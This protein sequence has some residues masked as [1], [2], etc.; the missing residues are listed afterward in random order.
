MTES[1]AIIGA[2]RA[3]PEPGHRRTLRGRIMRVLAPATLV[4]FAVA[5]IAAALYFIQ[6]GRSRLQEQ[7]ARAITRLGSAA[8]EFMSETVALAQDVAS[9]AA[10]QNYTQALVAGDSESAVSITR[11]AAVESLA[12]LLERY[13][14]DVLIASFVTHSGS[15]WGRAEIDPSGQIITMDDAVVDTLATD[16]V[17]QVAFNAPAG[18]AVPRGIELRRDPTNPDSPLAP[19]IRVFMPVTLQGSMDVGGLIALDVRADDLLDA[20]TRAQDA[21]QPLIGDTRTLVLDTGG[22]VLFDSANPNIVDLVTPNSLASQTFPTINQALGAQETLALAS[23]GE[24]VISSATVSF[25]GRPEDYLRIV[26]INDINQLQEAGLAQAAF[27]IGGALVSGLVLIGISY[28]LLGRFTRPVQRFTAGLAAGAAPEP[29]EPL[30]EDGDEISTLINAY[31]G[32]QAHNERLSQQLDRQSRRFNRTFDVAARVSS[33]AVALTGLDEMLNRTIDQICREYDFYHA[34]VFLLDDVAKDAVLVYSYGEAGRQLLDRKHRLAVG[35]N[36]LVGQA[37]AHSRPMIVNDTAEPGDMPWRFNPLL[38]DTSAEMALPLRIGGQVLGVLDLQSVHSNAFAEEDMRSFLLLADQIAIA[39]NNARLL[40]QSQERI[41]QIDILNRQLTRGAWEEASEQ[42]AGKTYVYDLMQVRPVHGPASLPADG[43]GKDIPIAIRGEVVGS[44]QAGGEDFSTEDEA[45]LRAVADRVGIA[46]ENA[47]LFEQTES[48]LNDTAA[49]YNASASISAS[50][51]AGELSAALRTSLEQLGPDVYAAVLV[52]DDQPVDLFNVNLDGAPVEFGDLLIA[53]DTLGGPSSVFAPDLRDSAG[54]FEAAVGS[55]G[56]VR[57][58]GM[59]HLRAQGRPAGALIV[60]YHQPREFSPSDI[61]YLSAVADSASVVADNILL[62]DQ[63]QA[64][65]RETSILYEA[66]RALADARTPADVLEIAQRHLNGGRL[67]SA[68]IVLLNRGDWHR[69][70]A[71]ATIAASWRTDRGASLDGLSLR[72]EQF[73]AWSLLASPE[74]L[75]I[76][77]THHDARVS[78]VEAVG[79][80]SLDLRALAVLP[81]RSTGRPTG[82]LVLGAREATAF[83]DSDARVF[84]AF[85]EQAGLRLEASR[86]VQQTERRARQLATSAQVSSIASS[87]LDLSF[88]LP[89]L[90]DTI[91]DQFGYDHVQ[92]FLM[93]ELDENAVLRASTGEAGR[94]LLARNHMLQRGSQSV[95]GQVTATGKPV[96]AGDTADARVIHRPNPLLP[97]TRS[98]M[99]IPLILKGQVVGALDV[100]SNQPN[101][102]DDDDVAVLTTLAAQV[103]VAIDNAQLFEQSTQRASEMTFLFGVTN[104]AASSESLAEALDNVAAELV[105]SLDALSATIYLPATYYDAY[106][107]EQ[108]V[109]KPAAA[110]G[111]GLVVAN[112]PDFP[113]DSPHLIATAARERSPLIIDDLATAPDFAPMAADAKS[114]IIVPLS[115]GMQLAGIVLVESETTRAFGSQALTL[116]LTLSGSLSAIVQSQTL[117]EQLQQTNEQLRELDRLKNDFLANMS[118]E[119]RTPLNSIIGFSKVILKGI[120][121][122][123]TEMQEQDLSTIY[124]SGIHLLNLINDILDQAKIAAGKMDLHFDYFDLKTC[125]D[126]VRS[127]GIGLVKDKPISLHVEIGPGLPRAFGD[128]LRTRQVL[129]NLVSNAAKFTSEGSITIRAYQTRDADTGAPMVRTDVIDTGIGIA[130]GDIPLLFEAFRQVDSSLTRTVGGTGLGLPIARSLIE[131]MGGSMQ[132][133]SAPNAGSTFSIILPVESADVVEAVSEPEAPADVPA[134]APPTNGA[135][136]GRSY[137]TEILPRPVVRKKETSEMRAVSPGNGPLLTKRQMLL[138]EDNPEMVDQYRRLL[139]RE[140]FDVYTASIPLEAEAMASGLHPTAIVMDASFAGGAAWD[141]LKRLKARDDTGDIPVLIVSLADVGQQA[142]EAGAFRVLR[143]PFSPDALIQAVNEAERESRTERILIIDD[144]PESVRLLT[145]LLNEHGRYRVFS[146]NTGAEGISLVARRRPD[147][148]LLDLRMP[149]MDGFAVIEELRNNPETLAI[150]ILVVT[151]ETLGPE[152]IQRLNDLH[153][154]YKTDLMAGI[155]R[156]FLDEVRSNLTDTTGIR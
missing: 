28:L 113:L 96:V 104:A 109:L 59:V 108:V 15:I 55:L 153:V 17:A 116:M 98:E 51:D 154:L 133:E 141:I 37:A 110:S 93:D 54:P 57:A 49:L 14:P 3:A 62:L 145:E 53:T 89:R 84:S 131:M 65:L 86:L 156:E 25:P 74:V 70:E 135:A 92:I 136:N 29:A 79:L 112:L 127:I 101:F 56:V 38:P 91:R 114:A 52:S 75:L 61:R 126:A 99:A 71:S 95:I 36:S 41:E 40:Q 118:H 1:P 138:I 76:P 2:V 115:T 148:I 35:S 64:N 97:N 72:P 68:F 8:T 152:E 47:R 7:Q 100:Q 32:L 42:V 123:L 11:T 66:T 69:P 24:D 94:K 16:P 128:E 12:R 22:H 81:L 137:E 122:P 121:G 103:S 120:D 34:Q 107:A 117:L 124:N 140:G 155:K 105:S 58:L 142:V 87:I 21:N 82:A 23:A 19:F 73:P 6:D 27:M 13:Y 90:V 46:L 146:A 78:A 43:A 48:A 33:E 106:G 39:M 125:I 77:D 150:P 143:R 134:L 119:L 149:G 151:N 9:S 102:F 67:T 85:A 139:Q 130:E 147:L 45:L 88:L 4:V 63:I 144:Q 20:L 10:I 132:V 80:E 129:L 111:A 26:A 83:A 50:R 44:L 30:A 60:G 18:Q 5:G 31:A